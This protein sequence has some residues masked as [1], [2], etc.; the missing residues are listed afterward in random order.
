MRDSRP[1]AL[2][3]IT[4]YVRTTEVGASMTIVNES[5]SNVKNDPECLDVVE[6][7]MRTLY[8][9]WKDV[10]EN[11]RPDGVP[12][13]ALQKEEYQEWEKE[14]LDESSPTSKARA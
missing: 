13:K 4:I 9:A 10:I 6:N 3:D 8:V 7:L 1:Y 11:P 5:W 14:T 12:S 2:Q